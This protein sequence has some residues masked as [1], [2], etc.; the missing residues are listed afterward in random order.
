MKSF[1]PCCRSIAPPVKPSDPP[2]WIMLDGN[3]GEEFCKVYR[4]A[5]DSRHY[6]IEF[7]NK[8][9]L[10]MDRPNLICC[11]DTRSLPF[12]FYCNPAIDEHVELSSQDDKKIV[13]SNQQ[14]LYGGNVIKKGDDEVFSNILT[15]DTGFHLYPTIFG[16][17]C[18]GCCSRDKMIC[19]PDLWRLKMNCI[20]QLCCDS[21]PLYEM[22]TIKVL[23]GKLDRPDVIINF[24]NE[25]KASPFNPQFD[26][27]ITRIS[28]NNNNNNLS[29]E[30]KL[31][32]IMTEI[33][34]HKDDEFDMGLI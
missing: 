23:H 33:I 18:L 19:T 32:C 5:E 8:V 25:T 7:P 9:Q 17:N 22:E 14:V 31:A 26:A 6:K 15:V 29:A 2:S 27:N 13:K 20:P 21:Q 12:A 34:P 4:I 1:F 11:G 28:F 30:E 3:N 24:K 16:C 10:I